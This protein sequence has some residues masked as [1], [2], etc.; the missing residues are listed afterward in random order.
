MYYRQQVGKQGEE[1]VVAYLQ[2]EGYSICA[3]NFSGH[4]GEV[5]I[6][7]QRGEVLAFVEVKARSS[8]YFNLSEVIVPSK[9]RK[10][11]KT[12]RFFIATN[13]YRDMVYRFDIALLAAQQN[14]WDITYIPNAFTDTWGAV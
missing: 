4:Y 8:L 10:I 14:S 5:D 3:R 9:Q 12:A 2:K 1:A 7:A 11:I 6:I 13:G